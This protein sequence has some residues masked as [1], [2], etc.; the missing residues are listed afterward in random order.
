[1]EPRKEPRDFSTGSSRG[2]KTDGNEE[3]LE[4]SAMS[5]VQHYHDVGCNVRDVLSDI[6]LDM[7]T[8]SNLHSW[9]D[10]MIKN[11]GTLFTTAC[12]DY[13]E[14][15]PGS[16]D[17]L[18][19]FTT[20]PR[21]SPAMGITMH[22]PQSQARRACERIYFLVWYDKTTFT[23]YTLITSLGSTWEDSHFKECVHA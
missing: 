2:K 17:S 16:L 23:R 21:L 8:Y 7:S 14:T 1:M 4:S 15:V 13:M 11:S 10:I 12:R 20:A 6:R 9:Y 5:H 3:L 22:C 19:T 18:L